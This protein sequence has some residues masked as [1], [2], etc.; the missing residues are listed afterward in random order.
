[1]AK[2][3]RQKWLGHCTGGVPHPS[4]SM[5][6]CDLALF[7]QASSSGVKTYITS[8]IRYVS[9]RPRL[10]HVVIVPGAADAVRIEG[11]SRVV[12]V[13]GV[14]SPYPG[15]FLG[16]NLVRIARLIEEEAPDI[17]IGRASCRERVES[18]GAA[19]IRMRV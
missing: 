4:A 16:L 14:P 11:R 7:D 3:D 13:R 1:M 15:V 17:K 6:I 8:K 18:S 2:C 12:S 9:R 5:K 19:C 10:D